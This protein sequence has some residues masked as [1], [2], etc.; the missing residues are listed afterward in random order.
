MRYDLAFFL[1]CCRSFLGDGENDD[2]EASGFYG[3]LGVESDATPDQIKRAYKRRSLQMHP[4]KLAQR[5]KPVTDE[6]RARFTRMKDAYECLSDPH[7]R[8]TYD[9]IGEKGMKWL[10]EPFSVD[11]QELAGNFARSS[12][13]DRS[14]IFAIFVGLAVAL[15]ALPVAV[16]LHLDGDLGDDASWSVTLVPLWIWNAMALFY[17]SRVLTM[18]TVSAPDGV[19]PEEWIDPFPMKDRI[20]SLFRFLLLVSAEILLALKLDEVLEC[21]WGLVFLPV[22]LWEAANV[23][24]QWPLSRLRTLTVEDLEAAL[25]KPLGECTAD[26]TEAIRRAY[27]VVPSAESPEFA[28]AEERKARAARELAKSA[29]RAIVLS[30]LA[31]RLDTRADWNWWLVFLPVWILSLGACLTDYLSFAEA[32]ASAAEKDPGLFGGDRDDPEAAATTRASFGASGSAAAAETTSAVQSG[33][34]GGPGSGGT[35]TN[36]GSVGADGAATPSAAAAGSDLSEEEKDRLREHVMNQGSECCTRCCWRGC[37]L[38]LM[39]LV[40]AKLQGA[41]FSAFWIISPFLFAAGIILLCLGFAIFGVSETTDGEERGAEFYSHPAASDI[42]TNAQ[43]STNI[44]LPVAPGTPDT[45]GLL[46]TA[47]GSSASENEMEIRGLD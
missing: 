37:F 11:P 40:A 35:A 43:P 18:P 45:R 19:P 6:D 27:V 33:E 4:D 2:G 25:G 5:G 23:H 29:A 44:V 31:V 41:A 10:D 22:Y 7:K 9:A 34:S 46:A 8:E 17:H 16:C 39:G 1:C 32:S 26:E 42:T 36:Y 13:L 47:G 28:E 15:L 3:L 30:A 24:E 20:R 21:A 12:V 14:K 38:L